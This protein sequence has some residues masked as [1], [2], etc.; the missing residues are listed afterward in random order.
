VRYVTKQSYLRTAYFNATVATHHTESIIMNIDVCWKMVCR[1]LYQRS[2][3]NW[4]RTVLCKRKLHISVLLECKWKDW[5]FL[6]QA[7]L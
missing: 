6:K 3:D 7:H 2:N 1:W 4:A 5:T